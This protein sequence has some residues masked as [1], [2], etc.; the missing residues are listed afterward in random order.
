MNNTNNCTEEKCVVC[1]SYELLLGLLAE[2][3]TLEEAHAMIIEDVI[4]GFIETIEEDENAYE[5]GHDDGFK[6]GYL[7]AL[8]NV[9]GNVDNHIDMLIG[10]CDCDGC[11]EGE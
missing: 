4:E 1:N 3:A 6:A 10:E 7:S 2:G 9:R 5:Q 8:Q 11:C